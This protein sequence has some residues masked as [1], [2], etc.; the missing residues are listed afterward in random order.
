MNQTPHLLIKTHS[1]LEDVLSEELSE[2][3]IPTLEKGLRCVYIPYSKENIYRCNM[4]LRTALRVLEPIAEFQ[5]ENADELYREAMLIKWE[6]Y[7]KENGTFAID[8]SGKS[9]LFTHLKF[10]SLRLKDALCDRFRHRTG[11]R[12]DVDK[13]DPDVLINLH[14]NRDKISVSIDTGGDSLHIRGSREVQNEAPINE[15]LAAGLIRLSGWD[16]HSEFV[17][18]MCGSGT[19]TSEAMALAFHMAPCLTR[20]EYAF[21]KSP[22]F[23]EPLYNTLMAEAEKCVNKKPDLLFR[24]NDLSERSVQ[25]ARR[26][27][28]GQGLDKYARFST[29]DFSKLKPISE[30]GVILLNPPYG[31]RMQTDNLRALYA[32]VGTA[33]KHA[34]PGFR[35]GI[36]SSDRDALNEIGLRPELNRTVFNGALECKFRVYS[37]YAGSKKAKPTE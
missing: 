7:L 32:S 10:A 23:D 37:L 26:N 34:W 18:G 3:H 13:Y 16:R 24:V 4:F 5:A 11:K 2:W 22:D 15:V 27:L 1:G 33:L 25:K 29:Q 14:V 6:K 19:F 12:P 9:D 17:D 28:Q 35:C 8:F 31:E 21:K 36:I 20:R 30:K